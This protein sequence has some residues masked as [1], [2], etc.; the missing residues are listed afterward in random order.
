[1]WWV[2]FERRINLEFKTYMD[3]KGRVVHLD[4]IKLK[5][6]LEKV[7][8][9]W[10]N[11][12]KAS[13]LVRFMVVT[14]SITYNQDLRE[15][16]TKVNTKFPSLST[17]TTHIRR[18]IQ[19]VRCNTRSGYKC[20]CIFISNNFG[21]LNGGFLECI[22]NTMVVRDVVVPHIEYQTGND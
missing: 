4:E 14:I 15:F 2:E 8:Y 1:M 22:T 11:P 19:K 12:I 10:K 13:I 17:T 20:G 21:R 7:K 5:T 9:N 6:L 16:K 3:N 18:H